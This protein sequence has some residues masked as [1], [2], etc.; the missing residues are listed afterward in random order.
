LFNLRWVIFGLIL[1]ALS[2]QIRIWFS[3]DGYRKSLKL[4]NAVADQKVLNNSLRTRN[5]ALDAE[6]LNLKQGSDAAEELARNDLGM[7]GENETFY[8]VIPR[9]ESNK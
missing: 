9:D 1:I 2:L 7:I 8:Q 4:K 3:D 5:N 6:V